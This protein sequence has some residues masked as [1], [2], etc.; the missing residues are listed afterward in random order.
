MIDWNGYYKFEV[1]SKLTLHKMDF[2]C[3]TTLQ[4]CALFQY[5]EWANKACT[6]WTNRQ[7]II[8]CYM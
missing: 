1:I 8:Q 2:A 6:I 5:T 4:D 7:N 3:M